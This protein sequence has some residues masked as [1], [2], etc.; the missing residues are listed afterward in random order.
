M[1]DVVVG[2]D[3]EVII[4]GEVVTYLPVTERYFNP[5][6]W[7][8]ANTLRNSVNKQPIVGNLYFI[9]VF[10]YWY[11]LACLTYFLFT[12]IKKRFTLKKTNI[13]WLQWRLDEYVR[14]YATS[15]HEPWI[16]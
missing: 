12:K 1:K 6:I 15:L 13:I 2:K 16:L 8:F 7:P 9:I 3:P 10:I 14:K 4:G 11:L 5:I